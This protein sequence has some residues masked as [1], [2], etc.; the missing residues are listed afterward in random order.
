MAVI[1][2]HKIKRLLGF[3]SFFISRREKELRMSVALNDFLIVGD[4]LDNFWVFL[5]L[6]LDFVNS[7]LFLV[8]PFG[9][10]LA[11]GF[12]GGDNVL[13]LPADVM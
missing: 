4:P 5:D 2:Q 1:E 7:L 10:D 6:L 13:V 9:F 8:E 3:Y 12:K 11:F